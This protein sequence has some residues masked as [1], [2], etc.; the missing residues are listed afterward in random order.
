MPK[1]DY[2][3]LSCG[4]ILELSGGYDE[5]EKYVICNGIR[6]KYRRI[7]SPPR[8]FILKGEGWAKDNYDKLESK[9]END[10]N[11]L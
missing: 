1:Y 4:N 7:F 9:G 5:V 8:N 11:N 10:G 6:S 3:C 2:K